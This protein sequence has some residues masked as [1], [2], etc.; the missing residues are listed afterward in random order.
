MF[1]SDRCHQKP[2]LNDKLGVVVLHVSGRDLAEVDFRIGVEVDAVFVVG[3][4]ITE[5]IENKEFMYHKR[6]GS[7]II[8]S[9]LHILSISC[10]EFPA[11]SM[12]QRTFLGNLGVNF[13]KI[14]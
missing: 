1:F 14:L 12:Y 2:F 8:V 3:R 11:I 7:N 4:I 10:C 13:T 5:I 6:L 9:F